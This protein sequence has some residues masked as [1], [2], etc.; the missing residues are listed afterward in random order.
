MPSEERKR[1]GLR[2]IREGAG[3][4]KYLLQSYQGGYVNIKLFL[5]LILTVD[6]TSSA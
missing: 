4:W 2:K 1:K 5:A 3:K 6:K